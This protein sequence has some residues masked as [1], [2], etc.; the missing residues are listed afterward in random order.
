[1]H[2]QVTDVCAGETRIMTTKGTPSYNISTNYGRLVD[3]FGVNQVAGGNT[4]CERLFFICFVR[5]VKFSFM[6]GEG[7]TTAGVPSS[8]QVVLPL[9]GDST[10]S[11]ISLSLLQ[12][13]DFVMVCTLLN[14]MVFDVF[15]GCHY[16]LASGT[17]THYTD[18]RSKCLAV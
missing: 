1:M 6:V 16:S 14:I 17:R 12:D 8:F 15:H 2:V 9:L 3:I 13:F 7:G 18:A 5:T 10:F 11:R 4:C